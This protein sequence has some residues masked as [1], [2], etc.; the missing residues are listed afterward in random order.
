MLFDDEGSVN[1]Y[2]FTKKLQFRNIDCAVL[3]GLKRNFNNFT[4]EAKNI[5]TTLYCIGR[6]RKS[7]YEILLKWS[8]H[9]DI[10]FQ[11]I[12]PQIGL[13]LEKHIIFVAYDLLQ[14]AKHSTVDSI[15]VVRALMTFWL[16]SYHYHNDLALLDKRT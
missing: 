8:I 4:G 13:K 6:A 7:T 1:W 11:K 9:R 5:F 16:Y 10:F 2:P 15:N 3:K 12:P 14:A